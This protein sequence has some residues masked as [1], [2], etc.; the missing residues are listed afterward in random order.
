M[1]PYYGFLIK[2]DPPFWGPKRGGVSGLRRHAQRASPSADSL[3]FRAPPPF[4]QP[5]MYIWGGGQKPGFWPFPQNA[6]F[7]K[8][9]GFFKK[10][11]KYF[12]WI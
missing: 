9:L 11:Q 3:F 8:K 12:K 1:G 7:L 4:N 5:L 10:I 2:N 6:S